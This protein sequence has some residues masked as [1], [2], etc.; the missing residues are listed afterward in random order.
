MKILALDGSTQWLSIALVDGDRVIVREERAGSA[1]S[2]R[3]VPL[4]DAVLAAAGLRLDELD[5]I[6][7]GA[8]PGAFTGVRIAC[9]VAQGLAL[10]SGRPLVAVATLEAL[11]QEAWRIHGATRVLACLDARMKEV[12]VAAYERSGEVWRETQPPAVLKPEAVARLGPEWFGAGDGFAIYPS[13]AATAG[14]AAIDPQ[15]RPSARAIAELALP[16]IVAGEGV[17][18]NAALPLYVRHRVA[19]TIA[20][21]AAGMRF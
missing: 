10:G 17:A 15:L 8:G 5:A 9:G 16:R 14:L 12:Y 19:L 11:A 21:R 13:L 7:F 2:E 20:E 1:N 4:V 3:I 6:A 18:A